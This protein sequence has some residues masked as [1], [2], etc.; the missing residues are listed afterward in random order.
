MLATTISF[1]L[2][3]CGDKKSG[4]ADESQASQATVQ[5]T[6]V[7][8][9][10]TM[11]TFNKADMNITIAGVSVQFMGDSSALI[12]A[13]GSNYTLEEENGCDYAGMV[14][15]YTYGEDIM[16]ST[17]PIDGT[18]VVGEVTI[19]S[20]KYPTSKDIK[21]GDSRE[22]IITAYGENFTDDDDDLQNGVLT[23][24][25]GEKGDYKHTPQLYFDLEENIITKI[26]FFCAGNKIS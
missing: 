11:G 22:K 21:V 15:Y 17:Y 23:Y 2:A 24:W 26:N 6:S 7:P 14:K 4:S 10:K 25:L 9:E 20:Q 5:N 1:S 3:S 18:E 12:A 13:L 8:S 19:M 16:I